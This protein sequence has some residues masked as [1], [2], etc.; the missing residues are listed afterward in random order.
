MRATNIDAVFVI[1][2]S[3]TLPWCFEDE[4]TYFT[5]SLLNRIRAY[6]TAMVPSHWPAEILN[7]LVQAKKRGR[8]AEDILQ[9]FLRDLNSFPILIDDK[10][11]LI[12]WER[13]RALSETHR[14][15]AYDAAYLELAQR[16]GLPLGTLD[17]DLQNAARTEK[18]PLLT[19][20]AP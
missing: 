14:L 5:E 16:H 9:R 2:A 3:V 17:Q 13:I 18:V 12:V 1:D 15:T 7:S 11:T 19:D 4:R 6:E 20:A 8:V 10:Q